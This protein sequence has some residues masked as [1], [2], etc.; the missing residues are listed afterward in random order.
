MITGTCHTHSLTHTGW[1]W[2]H[3][4]RRAGK[5]GG[6]PWPGDNTGW[7]EQTQPPLS[8]LWN[9]SGFSS[10]SLWKYWP[11]RTQELNGKPASPLCQSNLQLVVLRLEVC[12]WTC[13]RG[14]FVVCPIDAGRLSRR[15]SFT[16]RV[17]AKVNLHAL[18]PVPTLAAIRHNEELCVYECD[19]PV[20]P[21][22]MQQKDTRS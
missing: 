21:A 8:L 3:W 18:L 13:V 20:H 16:P 19:K 11:W 1:H 17:L 6:L 10:S 2:C 5:P 12:V 4:R 15:W 14:L 9:P 7:S 22:R